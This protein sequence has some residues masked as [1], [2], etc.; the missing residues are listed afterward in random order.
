MRLF[1]GTLAPPSKQMNSEFVKQSLRENLA[2]TL[3]P[4][5]A[6]GL[7]SIYDSAKSACERNKQPEKTLQTFQNL[8]TRIPQWSDS[9][10][11]TEVDRI[12]TA[13]KC[14]YIEDLLLGVFVSYIRAFAALQQVDSSSVQIDFERPSL[15]K[16][17]HSFYTLAARKS[18]TAA[19]L[20]KTI[21]TPSEQQARNRREIESMLE[22]TLSETIDSFIPWRTI[23]KAYFQAPTP[24]A[25]PAPAPAPAPEA[26]KPPV[27][28][29]TTNDV[30]EFETDDEESVAESEEEAPPAIKLGEDM[31]LDDFAEEET[32]ATVDDDLEAKLKSAEPISL[33]L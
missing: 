4:H 15:S 1:E 26:A 16:F 31:I 32:E 11:T 7:W 9:I 12:L 3:V 28:F 30:H 29:A 20:F 33:N 13:S 24:E 22:T 17:I 5:V 8:L 14:D 21:G 27:Q 18:W 6:D 2:R 19:Y 10:L 23:S 25:A